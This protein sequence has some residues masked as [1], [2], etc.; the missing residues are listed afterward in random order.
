[1]FQRLCDKFDLQ[2]DE[3]VFVDDLQKNVDGAIAAGMQ[4]Y[5]FADGDVKRL[6]EYLMNLE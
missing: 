3:C 2:M 6:R 4:G 5:C 1:M